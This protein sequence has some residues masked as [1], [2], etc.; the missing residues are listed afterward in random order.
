M[1]DWQTNLPPGTLASD[2]SPAELERDGGHLE[3]ELDE[4]LWREE[5]AAFWRRWYARHGIGEE[6]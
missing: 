6:I 2:I 5:D 3:R 1:I 4:R